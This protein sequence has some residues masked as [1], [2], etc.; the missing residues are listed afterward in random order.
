MNYLKLLV[1]CITLSNISTSEAAI[2]WIA[3]ASVLGSID[4]KQ[5]LTRAYPLGP[6]IAAPEFSFLLQLVNSTQALTIKRGERDERMA[7][8]RKLAHLPPLPVAPK[9][10]LQPGE[11]DPADAKVQT[12]RSQWSIPQ[13]T[14]FI[15]PANRDRFIWNPPGGGEIIFA[16]EDLEGVYPKFTPEGWACEEVAPGIYRIFDREGWSWRYENGLPVSLTA[17]SGRYLEFTH[18]KGLLIRI[19][20]RLSVADKATQ[21]VVLLVKYDAQLH[22]IQIDSGPIEHRFTYDAKTGNLLA[23]HSTAF[24]LGD[25]PDAQ[26]K[27]DEVRPESN[28]AIAIAPG[29]ERQN[30]DSGAIM[31]AIRFAY[32]NDVLVAAQFPSGKVERFIWD[33]SKGQLLADGTYRYQSSRNDGVTAIDAEGR[34]S[35]IGFSASRDQLE[36]TAPDGSTT[37]ESYQRKSAGRGLLRSKKGAGGEVLLQIDYTP[38]HLVS[39]VRSLGQP[40]IRNI[41]DNRDRVIE[42]WRAP[43]SS[44]D[45]AAPAVPRKGQLWQSYTYEGGSRKPATMTDALGQVS[46]FEYDDRGQLLST[47]SPSGARNRFAYDTWGRVIRHDM[48]NGSIETTKYD[49]WGRVVEKRAVDGTTSTFAYDPQGRMTSR[50]EGG[51]AYVNRYDSQGRPSEVQRKGKTWLKWRYS[52]EYLTLSQP[53]KAPAGWPR[54]VNSVNANVV[55]F[56]DPRGCET[57]RYFDADGHLMEVVNPAGEHTSYRYNKV[58]EVLGWVDARDNGLVFERDVMG[59]LTKQVNALGQTLSWRFDSAGR[60]STRDNGVQT[61]TYHYDP[62]GRLTQIDYGKGQ[63]VNYERDDFGRLTAASTGEVTTIYRYD[64]LD[65]IIRTEQRP[66]QGEASGMAY[67]Y[68]TDG[69]KDI[70][71]LLGADSAGRLVP[72]S[73]THTTYDVLGR[74]L[75]IELDGTMTATNTYDPRTLKLATK[76][77]GNGLSYSYTYDDQGQLEKL[78]VLNREGVLRESLTYDWDDNGLLKSRVLQKPAK[79]PKIGLESVELRYDYDKLGR[80]ATV[81]SVQDPS[82]NRSYRYDGAGNLVENRSADRW[83]KMEYDSANQLVTKTENEAGDKAAPETTRFS[84]DAAGRMMSEM[85]GG[86]MERNFTYGYL[87]KVMSVDRPNNQHADYVYDANGMLVRKGVTGPAAAGAA[88]E[89]AAPKSWETWVWDGLALVQRGDEVFVNEAHPAGGQAIMSRTLEAEPAA[90]TQIPHNN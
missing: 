25:A 20:Q 44:L 7:Y 61:A 42:V 89:T 74:P 16:R 40:E 68:S 50:T 78:D 81:T 17:P 84:Y 28:P 66:A 36:R 31:G 73:T 27:P 29:D 53:A 49:E 64:A 46:R 35:S 67:V 62:A 48:P 14:S 87:D 88:P 90:T 30:A 52:N 56:I 3:D 71:T 51:V 1:W 2:Q 32:L 80:L 69:A 85:Q 23:W 9:V 55:T 47:F 4:D 54:D 33:Y 70:S 59:R 38:R 58:G 10:K 76:H 79:A 57:K 41:Y 63:V 75:V 21:Q 5:A 26:V 34:K 8:L 45:V 19:V 60:L 18:D 77:L 37:S 43:V 22:P 82:Q 86:Q 11:P 65:R 39:A 13:L 15:Y 83:I 72:R 6:T 24:K 12:W